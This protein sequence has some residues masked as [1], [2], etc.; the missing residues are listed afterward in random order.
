MKTATNTVTDLS[1]EVPDVWPPLAHLILKRPVKPGDRAICG[2]KL[3]GIDLDNTQCKVCPK[4]VEI[5]W[6]NR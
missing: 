4:C 6:R 2:A 3:M 5:A 1:T